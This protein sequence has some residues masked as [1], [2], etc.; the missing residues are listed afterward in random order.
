MYCLCTGKSTVK[1]SAA[2]HAPTDKG[3]EI[4]SGPS[5]V[6]EQAGCQAYAKEQQSRQYGQECKAAAPQVWSVVQLLLQIGDC[7]LAAE[8][9]DCTWHAVKIRGVFQAGLFGLILGQDCLRLC[10]VWECD[11]V[12]Q[13]S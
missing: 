11:D 12:S 4:L 7:Q 3:S 9:S 5:S 13:M 10:L 6:Y 1:A 8:I 2:Q